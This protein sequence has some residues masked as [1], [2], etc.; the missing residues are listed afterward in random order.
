M[1]RWVAPAAY[2]MGILKEGGWCVLEVEISRSGE[3]LRFELLEQL[4]LRLRMI[5]PG[6]K[7]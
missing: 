6:V 5:Y 2:S 4:V 3:I 1:K 7:R